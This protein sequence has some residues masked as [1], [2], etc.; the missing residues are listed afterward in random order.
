MFVELDP[1]SG[2]RTGE[3]FSVSRKEILY[4]FIDILRSPRFKWERAR[5]RA[6][7]GPMRKTFGKDL[8]TRKPQSCGFSLLY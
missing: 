1:V 8:F 4:L 5:V 2:S 6:Y 3:I 7:V